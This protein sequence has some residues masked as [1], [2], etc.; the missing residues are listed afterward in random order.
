[1]QLC[2]CVYALLCVCVCVCPYMA[3]GGLRIQLTSKQEE[4]KDND[5]C[6]AEVEDHRSK[7]LQFQLVEV[8]VHTE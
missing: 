8:V 6:V 3:K 4:V 5:Q 7:I 2:V 1:M